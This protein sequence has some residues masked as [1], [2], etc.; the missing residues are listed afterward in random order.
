[1]D[2]IIVK[3]ELPHIF[4]EEFKTALAKALRNLVIDIEFAMADSILVKSKLTDE[5]TNQLAD[6]VDKKVAKKLGL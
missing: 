4:K 3:F 6:K 2:E 5:Q 1:M